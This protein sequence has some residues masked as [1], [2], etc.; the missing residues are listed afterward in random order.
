MTLCDFDRFVPAA[1]FCRENADLEPYNVSAETRLVVCFQ[2]VDSEKECR[3]SAKHPHMQQ[4]ATRQPPLPTLSDAARLALAQFRPVVAALVLIVL[5]SHRHAAGDDQS[6]VQHRVPQIAVALRDTVLRAVADQ[7]EIRN[8]RVQTMILGSQVTGSQ[9]TTTSTTLVMQPCDNGARFH[10]VSRGWVLTSTVSANPQ[11]IIEGTGAH[12]FEVIKPVEFDGNNLRTWPP[13]GRIT[14]RQSPQRVHSRFDGVPVLGVL[15]NRIAWSEVNRRQ[16]QINDSVAADVAGDVLNQVND[17][18]DSSLNDLNRQ[19]NRLRTQTS[20]WDSVS[21]LEWTARSTADSIVLLGNDVRS[22]TPVNDVVPRAALNLGRNEDV[23]VVISESLASRMAN[24]FIPS[25]STIADTQLLAAMSGQSESVL[26]WN[27]VRTLRPA[28]DP[29]A[30][31]FSVALPPSD[32]V[33]FQFESGKIHATLKGRVIP[34]I[35]IPSDLLTTRIALTGQLGSSDHW[36]LR[37]SQENDPEG[38]DTTQTG[39]IWGSAVANMTSSI[40]GQV[41]GLNITRWAPFA[42]PNNLGSQAQLVQIDCRDGVLRAAFRL[43]SR[44]FAK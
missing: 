12:N 14:A 6:A 18:V 9:T 34:R 32:S 8:G 7:E 31:L 3:P 1:R 39:T 35:G 13:H 21:Q 27:T 38:V 4:Q 5:L 28:S 40:I 29:V 26:D 20:D 25:G 33:Q 23:V 43:S 19:L 2:A 17:T 15:G 42:L 16:P 41:D 36:T 44:E 10:I 24:Q 22:A 37:V 11:V 30:S